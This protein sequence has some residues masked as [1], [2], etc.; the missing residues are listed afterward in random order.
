MRACGGVAIAMALT[1]AAPAGQGPTLHDVEP[2]VASCP[3]PAEPDTTA[4]KPVPPGVALRG[5]LHVRCGF[6]AGS[7]T[8]TLVSTDPGAT[9]APKTFLVNFG[10]IAGDGGFLVTFSNPGVHAVSASITANMGSPAVPG[11]FASA[12]N[13]FEVVTR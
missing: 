3:E 1:V 6:G 7:Y 11:R 12:D 5:R 10:R 4:A 13:R 9:F 8:V 2:G